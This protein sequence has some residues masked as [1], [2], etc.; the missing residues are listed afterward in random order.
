MH[1]EY[2]LSLVLIDIH[3]QVFMPHGTKLMI[4]LMATENPSVFLVK[5]KT[6]H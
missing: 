1:I 5:L 3:S 6:F 4:H 2:V